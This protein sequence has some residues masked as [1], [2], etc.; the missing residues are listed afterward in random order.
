MRYDSSS[1]YSFA[2]ESNLVFQESLP[3]ASKPILEVTGRALV[4]F[5]KAL[6]AG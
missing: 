2:F 4:P 1:S 3:Q 5:K 6:L